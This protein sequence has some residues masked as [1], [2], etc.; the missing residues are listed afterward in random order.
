MTS[1]LLGSNA[2]SATERADF[3]CH[4]SDDAALALSVGRGRFAITES[5][6]APCS[7]DIC[8]AAMTAQITEATLVRGLHTMV[9]V[10]D[11]TPRA[12]LVVRTPY[13]AKAHET[14]AREWARRGIA[15]VTRDVRERYRSSGSFH[16]Y[17]DEDEAFY[18]ESRC[19]VPGL[20]DDLG[21]TRLQCHLLELPSYFGVRWWL[22]SSM[23]PNWASWQEDSPPN[24]IRHSPRARRS[25]R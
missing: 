11:A 16:L 25:L 10:P 22:Q 18:L 14:E 9:A 12:V 20:I 17:R 13:D 1:K 23:T 8:C 2:I 21:D 24:S 4:L 3:V 6:A 19:R 5:N 15:V 7:S